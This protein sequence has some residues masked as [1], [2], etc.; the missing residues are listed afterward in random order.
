MEFSIQNVIKGKS[1]SIFKT[2]LDNLLR[3]REGIENARGK[4]NRVFTFDDQP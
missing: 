2:E 1:L 4:K 3:A